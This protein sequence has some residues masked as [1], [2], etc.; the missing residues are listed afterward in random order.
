MVNRGPTLSPHH[1]SLAALCV[2]ALVLATYAGIL[3]NQIVG[4]P[5]SDVIEPHGLWPAAAGAFRPL[6]S[7]TFAFNR[8]TT[9]PV[10][11]H[12]TNLLLHIAV[13]LVI[14]LLCSRVL[15]DPVGPGPMSAALTF[16]VLP[17]GVDA[18]VWSAGRSDVLST[19]LSVVSVLAHARGRRTGRI[20]AV[21]AF[22]LALLSKESALCVLPILLAHDLLFRGRPS[23][24]W[25][26]S[27]AGLLAV[28][29]AYLSTQIAV[30]SPPTVPGG[31]EALRALL[32]GAASYLPRIVIPHGLQAFEAYVP[33]S[34]GWSSAVLLGMIAVTVALLALVR[35]GTGTRAKVAAFGWFW[36]LFG[37]APITL[38]APQVG[39]VGDRFAYFP[40][41]GLALAVAGGLDAVFLWLQARAR[42]RHVWLALAGA[43]GLSWSMLG[44]VSARR[45]RDWRSERSLFEAELQTQPDNPIAHRAMALIE[46]RAGRYEAALAHV[47]QSKTLAPESWATNP[48]TWINLARS[49]V[50]IERWADA[51]A[52]AD[53]A[54][55]LEPDNV[56]ALFL[57]ALSAAKLGRSSEA[58]SDVRRL[59]ELDEQHEGAV[60]LLRFWGESGS[61]QR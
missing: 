20:V 33:L 48:S 57:R 60:E 13:A 61:N 6:T 17:V 26:G 14:L 25:A 45:T 40:A 36:C 3:D 47:E 30:A 55:R 8:L 22:G 32:F 9:A 4:E 31:I 19:F 11:F 21:V 10:W 42:A 2:T 43:M 37:L 5:L 29:V 23:R 35:F 56:N 7:L 50:H 27:Y 34:L 38:V 53:T 12:A 49:Y 46:Q 44:I 52:A 28:L 16:G 24:S 1:L 39:E 15:G 59:L 51:L 54:L 18:V 58:Q 41:V